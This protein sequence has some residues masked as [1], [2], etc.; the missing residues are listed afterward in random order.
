MEDGSPPP[1]W[2]CSAWSLCRVRV[3]AAGNMEFLDVEPR[4]QNSA[5]KGCT[6]EVTTSSNGGD[7]NTHLFTW[8]EVYTVRVYMCAN[9]HVHLFMCMC[10]CVLHVCI[11]S[12]ELVCRCV[13]AHVCKCACVH[14]YMCTC[15]HVHAHVKS[16]L[17][18]HMR[19]H[20]HLH[21]HK[22]TVCASQSRHT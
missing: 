6:N 2:N 19:L 3:Q 7:V 22:H 15:I 10:A 21:I 9:V 14:A 4:S 1:F 20:V 16:H 5:G 13:F 17:Q 8:V 12:C 11:S 18:M